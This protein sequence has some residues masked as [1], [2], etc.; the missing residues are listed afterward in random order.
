[1]KPK[2]VLTTRSSPLA[3]KQAEIVKNY[4]LQKGLDA[5]F[6]LLPLRT[7]GDKN[8]DWNLQ[9]KGGKGLFTKE[10]E[11]ALLK[12]AAHIAV[13]SAKDLPTALPPGLTLAAFVPREDPSDTLIIKET[14]TEP[15][16]IASSSPR[17][18]AQA[19]WLYPKAEFIE[20]RGNVHTRLKK[21]QTGY[22]DATFLAQA[23]LNRLD[24]SSF[25][26]LRF[27][28]M[29]FNEMV[30]AVG[31]GAIA[32][33][34]TEAFA[35]HIAAYTDSAT[36][37]AVTIERLFLETLGGGCQVAFGATFTGSKLII[38]HEQLRYHEMPFTVD[39]IPVMRKVMH[40]KL[41]ALGLI[42][43]K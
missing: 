36:H 30:P 3:L 23:A 39:T 19:K 12:G 18:S 2:L 9:E 32:L 20:I 4:L 13:H 15:R 33:E 22:A 43:L 27:Q 40:A 14:L 42:G 1:M 29:A 7:T 24:L 34:C 35:E 31:Q 38:F 11:E 37:N 17:R 10:L 16:C 21:I 26:G 6:E 25:P 28:T 41:D 5:D 8:R